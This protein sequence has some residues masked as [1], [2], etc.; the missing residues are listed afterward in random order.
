MTAQIQFQSNDWLVFIEGV[1]VPFMNFTYNT[2]VDM[3]PVGS[4][5]LIPDALIANIRPNAVVSLFFRDPYV[6]A[7]KPI[8]DQYVYYGGGEVTSVG[9][10]KQPQSKSIILTFRSELGVFAQHRMMA[11]GTGG[12]LYDSV[13]T[14][15]TI[16]SII[17]G[18]PSAPTFTM[19]LLN[20][21][22]NDF[23]YGSRILGAFAWFAAHNASLRLR[24]DQHRLLN[25]IVFLDNNFVKDILTKTT[26]P[27]LFNLT[28]DAN[29]QETDSALDIIYKLNTLIDYRITFMPTPRVKAEGYFKKPERIIPANSKTESLVNFA[30]FDKSWE[31]TDAILM[32]NTHYFPPP[33]CNYIFPD[34]V[35]SLSYSRTFESE[36]T[37]SKY[38]CPLV[39]AASAGPDSVSRVSYYSIDPLPGIPKG[40]NAPKTPPEFYAALRE[41]YLPPSAEGVSVSEESPYITTTDTLLRFSANKLLQPLGST[42]AQPLGSQRSVNSLFALADS[43]ISKGII[44]DNALRPEDGEYLAALAQSSKNNAD[45]NDKNPIAKAR[46]SVYANYVQQWVDYKHGLSRFNRVASISLKG[47][48]WLAPGFPAVVF[49]Q[50]ICLWGLISSIS[51]T[52]DASGN[53][54]T[55]VDFSN[56]KPVTGI[57]RNLFNSATKLSNDISDLNKSVQATVKS[58]YDASIKGLDDLLSSVKKKGNLVI[59]RLT[60]SEL[61]D[62]KLLTKEKL[63]YMFEV[64]VNF[65]V[66]TVGISP[67]ITAYND[68]A[69]AAASLIA[70][71]QGVANKMVGPSRELAG[72]LAAKNNPDLATDW[73][74]TYNFSIDNFYD[75]DSLATTISNLLTWFDK[76]ASL[77]KQSLEAQKNQALAGQPYFAS[78]AADADKIGG[79]LV[80]SGQ[81]ISEREAALRQ[82]INDLERNYNIP[83]VPEFFSNKFTDIIELDRVYRELLGTRPFYSNLTQTP[84]PV[85]DPLDIPPLLTVQLPLSYF[86]SIDRMMFTFKHLYPDLDLISGFSGADLGIGDWVSTHKQGRGT[87]EWQHREVLRR[88]HT[89]LRQYLLTNGFE[90]SLRVLIS[91]EPT[92][93]FFYAMTPVQADWDRGVVVLAPTG[94]KTPYTWD[95][96]PIT[97]LVSLRDDPAVKARRELARDPS[98]AGS[99]RQE[100]IINY[101]RK[102]M[103]SRAYRGD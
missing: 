39:N 44:V 100:Q 46:G 24:V 60:Q 6:G 77:T 63:S 84:I 69:P 15:S 25:K 40:Q 79:A 42:T 95:Q 31:R 102:L 18:G 59:S 5:Q 62:P 17:D 32:P 37:R 36:P 51:F 4:I 72:A 86:E 78:T 98:L 58:V 29:L 80:K 12:S 76:I 2:G 56:A 10:S 81:D 3:L 71:A 27:G 43:E 28:L 99:F 70:T 103:G 90:G 83:R 9:V 101:S 23:N 85:L 82:I 73:L 68:F 30:G 11:S 88:G 57:P 20:L 97:R 21:A 34:M 94:D 93:T 8:E 16:Y 19:S 7:D 65:P 92:P 47:H 74:A 75:K 55:Q 96:S 89:T 35:E 53:E 49:D 50:S 1:Q 67:I 13:V 33:P 41:L 61:S 48:K 45:N 87:M 66:E 22:D 26:S 91:G 38:T 54:S 52:A 14:G 64:D